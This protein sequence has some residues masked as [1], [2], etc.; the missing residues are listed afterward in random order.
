M[1]PLSENPWIVIFLTNLLLQIVFTI[2]FRF[3]HSRIIRWLRWMTMFVLMS[4]AFFEDKNSLTLSPDPT[5]QGLGRNLKIFQRGFKFTF[6][7]SLTIICIL[8]IFTCLTSLYCWTILGS[9][10]LEYPKTEETLAER[11]LMIEPN[12]F[13]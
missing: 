5:I 3:Y 13:L 1:I 9:F 8:I 11:V 10:F 4:L 7:K 2:V 12:G 6:V